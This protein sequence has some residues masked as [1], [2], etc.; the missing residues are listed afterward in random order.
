MVVYDVRKGVV[1]VVYAR[2][3]SRRQNP[4]GAVYDD[5]EI[6]VAAVYA[7]PRAVLPVVLRDRLVLS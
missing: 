1:A 4:V 7:L 5:H 3:Q 6:A 2:S